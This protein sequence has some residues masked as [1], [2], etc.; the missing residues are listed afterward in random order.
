MLYSLHCLCNLLKNL[1]IVHLNAWFSG[2]SFRTS[3]TTGP[4]SSLCPLIFPSCPPF[5]N[6][7]ACFKTIWTLS[8]CIRVE[9]NFRT[10]EG[11]GSW[12]N[13][14]CDDDNKPSRQW[15]ETASCSNLFHHDDFWNASVCA[16]ALLL[17]PANLCINRDSTLRPLLTLSIWSRM[18]LKTTSHTSWVSF[19]FALC[20]VNWICIIYN[21]R[22]LKY[23]LIQCNVK[24]QLYQKSYEA[25]WCSAI[26]IY[27][28]WR[29]RDAFGS[30]T[31][32]LH[33]MTED[34]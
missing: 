5:L 20:C 17:Y 18:S 21:E 29:Y 1:S 13:S 2:W 12:N 30:F 25:S 23:S 6:K 8:Y 34:L 9:A 31:I 19:L 10:G 32:F 4:V 7:M 11:A 24:V 22:Y 28:W 27:F 33:K 3:S 16:D 15:T 14:H 26:E